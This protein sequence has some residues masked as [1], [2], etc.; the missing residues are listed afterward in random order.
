MKEELGD[1][2]KNHTWDL[3][4]LHLEMSI[5]AFKWV[6]KIKTQSN[7]PV[8]RY[9]ARLVTTGLTHEYSIDYE[10]TFTHISFICSLLA[11]DASQYLVLFLM[12]VKTAILNS[13]MSEE[14]DM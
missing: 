11:I 12:D 9:K 8:D 10:E 13:N 7:N 14:V 4:D 2:F 3:F 1:L 6:F 5:V